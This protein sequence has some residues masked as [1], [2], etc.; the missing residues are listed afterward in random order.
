M[1]IMTIPRHVIV[2][3]LRER[4]KGTRADWVERNLPEEVDFYNNRSLL[5]TLDLAETDLVEQDS[6]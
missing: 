3:K 5:A 1:R 6:K 2:A 4:G